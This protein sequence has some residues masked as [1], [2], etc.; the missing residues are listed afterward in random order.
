MTLWFASGNTHKKQELA[1]IF[2][3]AFPVIVSRDNNDVSTAENPAPRFAA[4]ELKIPSDEGL[5]FKPD[6]SGSSFSENAMIKARL[7]YE[8]LC[9]KNLF[10]T[11]DA[12]IADDSG[13]CVD[14]LD[15]RP[16]IYSARYCGPPGS[17][18]K[19]LSD[20]EKNLLLLDEM[21]KQENLKARFVCAMVL[22]FNNNNFYIA[23]ETCEG[24]IVENKNEIRGVN[25]FGYDPV[26]YIPEL[27]MTTAELSETEKNKISHRGKAGRAIANILFS[28][29]RKF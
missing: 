17:E 25:G 12:V 19:K 18:F 26:F 5:E 7:L 3:S 29:S 8:L 27:K 28:S 6:E 24:S 1:A 15:G 22:L 21:D 10:K 2:K 23:Q 4:Y 11:G 14:A 16:G 13:I 20:M 9:H